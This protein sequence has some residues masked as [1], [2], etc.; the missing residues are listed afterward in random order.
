[1][2]GTSEG[3]FLQ[4]SV[5]LEGCADP[6]VASGRRLEETAS[7]GIDDYVVIADVESVV[8]GEERHDP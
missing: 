7:E 1:M 8:D 2:R 3:A 5:N 6:V 4:P